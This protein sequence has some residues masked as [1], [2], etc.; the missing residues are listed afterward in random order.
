[1]DKIWYDMIFIEYNIISYTRTTLWYNLWQHA[2]SVW[3]YIKYLEEWTV[4]SGL[5]VFSYIASTLRTYFPISFPFKKLGFAVQVMFYEFYHGFHH[6]ELFGEY[7]LFFSNHLKQVQEKKH[8][9][10][11][12]PP[13]ANPIGSMWLVWHLPTWMVPFLWGDGFYGR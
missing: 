10:I 6:H 5:T 4:T 12:F 3:V 13:C 1:M 7:L 11:L 8:P 9:C 2:L